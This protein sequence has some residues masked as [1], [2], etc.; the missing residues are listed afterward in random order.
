MGSGRLATIWRSIWTCSAF[1][2]NSPHRTLPMRI[3]RGTNPWD[4]D[5]QAEFAAAMQGDSSPSVY[6]ISMAS[7]RMRKMIGHSKIQ[8]CEGNQHAARCG[9]RL[10]AEKLR[11]TLSPAACGAF[12]PTKAIRP[13]KATL[14]SWPCL[15]LATKAAP[16]RSPAMQA[17]TRSIVTSNRRSRGCHFSTAVAVTCT[18]LIPAR[19]PMTS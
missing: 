12:R 17:F 7:K 13:I 3:H 10:P 16:M 6:E 14:R 18:R 9:R 5:F 2:R 19:K 8:N 15:G 1:G 11:D 4:I